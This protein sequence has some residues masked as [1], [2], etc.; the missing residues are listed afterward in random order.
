MQHPLVHLYL[1]YIGV[2]FV[3]LICSGSRTPPEGGAPEGEP[4]DWSDRGRAGGARSSSVSARTPR[5]PEPPNSVDGDGA[6]I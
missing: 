1:L 2:L 4:L 6:G 3:T 5:K